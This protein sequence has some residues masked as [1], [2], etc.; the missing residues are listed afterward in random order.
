[1]NALLAELAN[2]VTNTLAGL[3]FNA[4]LS[5]I[6]QF[7]LTTGVEVPRPLTPAHVYR[8]IPSADSP[9]GDMILRENGRSFGRFH[10]LSGC[11]YGYQSR[12][13]NDILEGKGTGGTVKLSPTEAVERVRDVVRKVGGQEY[14]WALQL[15]PRIEGPHE[16]R[17][18]TWAY[19]TITF[20]F[21]NDI[22]DKQVAEATIDADTGTLKGLFI[23]FSLRKHRSMPPELR[24]MADSLRAP[25]PMSVDLEEQ[26]R[27]L[28]RLSP[29]ILRFSKA[30]GIEVPQPLTTNVVSYGG[31]ARL[32]F[33]VH[34]GITF[35]NDTEFMSSNERVFFVAAAGAFFGARPVDLKQFT[36]SWKLSDGQAVELVRKAVRKLNYRRFSRLMGKPP[37][38][39]E[40][41]LIGRRDVPRVT[42]SWVADD[43]SI[44]AEVDADRGRIMML[45]LLPPPEAK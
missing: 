19:Y 41:N 8:F 16:I 33:S 35:T 13:C 24:A 9:E 37:R 3:V 11:I 23:D 25:Q 10:Y 7:A 2:Q 5:Q 43:G 40:P 6:D 27:R 4:M 38:V 17:G 44:D 36:G 31:P 14:E 20:L 12:D 29:Q 18:K 45:R 1:M 34:D 39:Y 22:E 30:L 21:P 15:E 42:V 28:R 32:G 26:A